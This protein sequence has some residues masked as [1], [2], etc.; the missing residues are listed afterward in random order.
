[1]TVDELRASQ[2]RYRALVV[3]LSPDAIAVI[4]D[5]RFVF[6]NQQALSL[7]GAQNLEELQRKPAI[8]VSH[9][10]CERR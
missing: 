1:M 5:G 8:E 3:E 4:Q 10:R 9:R 6:A 7:V 2:E